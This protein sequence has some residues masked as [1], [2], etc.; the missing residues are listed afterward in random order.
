[1]PNISESHNRN[2]EAQKMQRQLT[3]TSFL[4]SCLALGF[5]CSGTVLKAEDTFN[6][7]TISVHNLSQVI[8][9][10]VN[11]PGQV[12]GVGMDDSGNGHG[13]LYVKGKT[14]LL[15]APGAQPGTT[16]P[17]AINDLGQIVGSYNDNTT[18]AFKQFLYF[19]GSFT[20]ID[21][22]GNPTGMNNLGDIVGTFGSFTNSSLGEQGFLYSHGKVTVIDYPNSFNTQ[23]GGI[24]DFEQ[25]VGWFYDN[26]G[27]YH[28]FVYG[29]GAYSN[30]INFPGAAFT[31]LVGIND[32][33][34]IIGGYPNNAFLYENGAFTT[35]KFPNPDTTYTG[36]NSINNRGDILGNYSI[37]NTLATTPFLA[38]PQTNPASVQS[39]SC[40]ATS[41]T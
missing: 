7:Q 23:L 37:G 20:T 26:T 32:E 28:G 29:N 36:V 16:A 5:L 22:P 18:G 15:D 41:N 39:E 24:N 14:T 27:S 31:S 11:D 35:I 2:L 40:I 1:M 13:F 25:I 4:L 19:N 8:A 34:Q 9:Y 6:Y 10:G 33:G 3:S 30:P 21:L 17:A 38:V 12:V